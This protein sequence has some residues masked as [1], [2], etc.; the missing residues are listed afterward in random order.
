[1]LALAEEV[2]PAH[3]GRRGVAYPAALITTTPDA[4]SFAALASE[5]M[6]IDIRRFDQARGS[7][8]QQCDSWN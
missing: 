6:R 2:P 7:E 8:L 4:K 1:L 3:R 5:T